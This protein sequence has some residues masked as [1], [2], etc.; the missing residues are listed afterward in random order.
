MSPLTT[1]PAVEPESEL[2][3]L[4]EENDML[5]SLV[6][7][8]PVAFVALDLQRRVKLW[9]HAA[10]RIFGWREEEVIGKP[11]PHVPAASEQTSR[12]LYQRSVAGDSLRDIELDRM[13]KAGRAVRVSLSTS[14]L[15]DIANNIIGMVGVYDDL[16]DSTAPEIPFRGLVEQSLVG[17]YI[18]QDGM[19]QY[20]NPRWAAMFGRTQQEMAPG[21]VADFI[22]PEDRAT[23]L[24]NLDKRISGEISTLFYHF[25]GLHKEGRTVEIEVQ[26][27]RFQY[28]GRPAVIGVGIDVT[29]ARLREQEIAR[30]QERLRELSQHL[31]TVREEQRSQ[32][33]RELHDVLGGTLT[34]LKMD[35]GWLKK[36]TT[37][38]R[39]AARA[40]TMMELV[41]DA[42]DTVRKISAELRPG[43]LD[44]LGLLD[45]IEWETGR[46]RERMG[47]ECTLAMHAGALEIGEAAAIAIFRIFQEA[48]TNIA[49]HAQATR[50]DID[51]VL[52]DGALLLSVQDN[53][54]GL[55]RTAADNRKSFGLTGMAER[56][57]QFGATLEIT[58]EPGHGT[59][60]MLRFPLDKNEEKE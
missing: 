30:S 54:K 6:R 51:A 23:V 12:E 21:P 49:R 39:L 10:E 11:L 34:A 15:R 44:N 26:G 46:F 13:T 43:V 53:G 42:I 38:T 25:K 45:A 16:D 24:G 56:A 37:E 52:A 4:R 40:D 35:I 60:V 58:G 36:H 5:R 7:D 33:A 50:V 22:S 31:L 14:P 55:D 32:L 2:Q 41:R 8:A 29:D 28:R 48:L 47:I 27:T 19:F 57:R 3:R 20:V 9:N 1:P 59:R 17:L 18:I